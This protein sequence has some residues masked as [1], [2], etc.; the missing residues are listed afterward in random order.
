MSTVTPRAVAADATARPA[1]RHRNTRAA[2]FDVLRLLSVVCL[3]P[4]ACSNGTDPA[5]PAPPHSAPARQGFAYAR[6]GRPLT[7]PRDFGSHPEFQTEWWYY[8]GNL[9][10]EANRHF[11][12]QLT[13]FRRSLEPPTERREREAPMAANEVFMG[14]LAVTDCTAGDHRAFERFGR[15]AAP[16][17]GVRHSPHAIW[18]DDWRVET[19]IDG[20]RHLRAAEHG[21]ALDLFLTPSKGPVLHGIEGYSRKGEDPNRASHYYSFPR[22]LTRGSLSV[23]GE[24]LEVQGSSWMD[25]EL[26]SSG[27]ADDQVGWDWFSIQLDNGVELMLFHLRNDDGGVDPYSSGSLISP[28]GSVTTLRRDHFVVEPTGTWNSPRTAGRYPA[29]WRISI[30]GHAIDLQLRPCV[31]DQELTLSFVYWEGAVEVS[32]TV[33]DASVAGYG[34]VELTGYARSMQGTF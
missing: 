2:L 10:T 34:Y 28:A 5:P 30:P 9:R 13:F 31:P 24:D 32:G 1:C 14:H 3:V 19:T 7:F 26:T 22:L 6:E 16:V 21:I 27:L 12:Y 4:S 29:G 20:E 17:A 11:G 33:G 25:H 15:G 18:L 8:T 23:N